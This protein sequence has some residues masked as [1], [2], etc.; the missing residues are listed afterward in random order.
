MGD[1]ASDRERQREREGERGRE[2]ERDELRVKVAG[3][4]QFSEWL[5]ARV[6]CLVQEFLGFPDRQ[7]MRVF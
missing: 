2:G 4:R 3:L 6:R 1:R 7:A 5:R